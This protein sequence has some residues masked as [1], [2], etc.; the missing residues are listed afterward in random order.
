MKQKY[1]SLL[2]LTSVLLAGCRERPE[3]PARKAA[4]PARQVLVP[5][6]TPPPDGKLTEK[7]IEL[8]M[9]VRPREK[10]IVDRTGD[11]AADA[12]AARELGRDPAEYQWVKARV[13]EAVLTRI[14][15]DWESMD[16]GSRQAMLDGMERVRDTLRDREDRAALERRI[17][18]LRG[19]A[20]EPPA[21]PALRHNVDLVARHQEEMLRVEVWSILAEEEG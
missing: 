12:R 14:T 5:R 21:T 3:E 4:V 13:A 9:K 7:Q 18:Q 10:Q 19:S 15:A 8:F 2:I 6:F 20:P 17:A 1:L 16:E 11:P